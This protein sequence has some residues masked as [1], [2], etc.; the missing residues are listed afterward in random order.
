MKNDRDSVHTSEW[1]RKSEI[2]AQITQMLCGMSC[3]DLH[4]LIGFI[5]NIHSGHES[6]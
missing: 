1:Q 5:R 4:V 3:R 6:N 2:I